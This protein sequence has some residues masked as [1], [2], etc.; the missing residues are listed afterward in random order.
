MEKIE[1]YDNAVAITGEYERLK[2]GGYI[3][4]I[5]T[6]KEEKSRSGNRM[7]TIF[8]DIDEGENKGFFMKRYE[9]LKKENLDPNVKVKY[10]SG[11]IYHQMIEGNDKAVNFLKGLMTSLEASNTGFRW[12]WDEKKLAGLRCGAIFGEEEYEKL[13][14]SIGTST[15]VKF[16]RTVKAIQ[17]KNFKIPEI[18]KLPQ[19]GDSFINDG[20]LPF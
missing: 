19:K 8:L 11:G 13:D 1:G 5:I 18:K 16:I 2:A 4:K 7:L 20:E 17:D 3:C 12:D 9:E 15:K 14:G 10:P 6:A